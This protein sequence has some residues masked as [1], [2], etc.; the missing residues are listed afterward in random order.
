MDFSLLGGISSGVKCP[1]ADR[2]AGVFWKRFSSKPVKEFFEDWQEKYS[3]L[4]W[5][6][7]QDK[8]GGPR[9]RIISQES[10][11]T[12]SSY[13]TV[14]CSDL[15][16]ISVEFTENPIGGSKDLHRSRLGKCGLPEGR[17]W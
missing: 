14:S 13:P 7:I 10:M 12:A 1:Q 11:G 15:Q 17:V 6:P 5:I 4:E 16:E 3:S 2:D 9:G 8:N